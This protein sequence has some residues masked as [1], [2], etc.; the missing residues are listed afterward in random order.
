MNSASLNGVRYCSSLTFV[1]QGA[2]ADVRGFWCVDSKSIRSGP[3]IIDIL[4]K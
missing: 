4:L 2:K 1:V 3:S